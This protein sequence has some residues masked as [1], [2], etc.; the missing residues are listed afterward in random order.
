MTL[1]SRPSLD[2]L[3]HSESDR[4]HQQSVELLWQPGVRFGCIEAQELLE[5]HGC[6]VDH[7][8]LAVRI[9]A[10]I[11]DRALATAP[12]VVKLAARNPAHDLVLDRRRRPFRLRQLAHAC[13]RPKAI[14]LADA[15]GGIEV[16]DMG[17]ACGM[18]ALVL[19][20]S[21]SGKHLRIPIPDPAYIP[22]VLEM[23][24]AVSGA[25]Q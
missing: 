14:C 19:G 22:L 12:R 16:V 24:N 1:S 20:L 4:L 9:P 23:A 7:D 3:P 17:D 18:P 15:L 13:R 21:V 8:R 5:A 25:D 6:A 2:L 11:V 10:K